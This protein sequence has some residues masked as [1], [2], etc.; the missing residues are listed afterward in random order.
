MGVSGY[1]LKGCRQEMAEPIY[2]MIECSPK[3]KRSLKNGTRA[4]IMP[5]Y[6]NGYKRWSLKLRKMFHFIK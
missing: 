5:I 2:H 6:K 4:N 3:Q 1:I